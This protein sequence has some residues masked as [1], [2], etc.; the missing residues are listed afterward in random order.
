MQNL[1]ELVFGN[2]ELLNNYLTQIIKNP[3]LGE[4]YSQKLK[5]SPKSFSKLAGFKIFGFKSLRRIRAENNVPELCKATKKYA[6]IVEIHQKQILKNYEK[7]QEQIHKSVV[8]LSNEIQHLLNLPS[9]MRKNILREKNTSQ[10]NKKLS[11]FLNQVN[12][13]LSTYERTAIKENDYQT[14]ANSIKVSEVQAQKIINLVKE[15]KTCQQEIKDII[16][17]QKKK[18]LAVAI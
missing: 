1:S 2:R 5:N 7:K 14:L 4:T 3:Q 17:S 9:D 10:I 13:R 12:S 18:S 8:M 6:K 16:S 11:V 15:A